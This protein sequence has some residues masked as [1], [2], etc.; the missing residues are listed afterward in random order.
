[1]IEREKISPDDG[2]TL[3]KSRDAGDEAEK[4]PLRLKIENFFY[5]YKWHTIVALFL[6]FAVVIS[7][8]QLCTRVENDVCLLYAGAADVKKTS[9][10][11]Q[12]SPYETLLSVVKT[13]VEDYTGDGKIQVTFEVLFTLSAEERAA[14]EQRLQDEGGQYSL[15]DAQLY[16]NANS[17][18]DNMT[19]GDFYVCLLSEANFRQ[20][21]DLLAEIAPYTNGNES[22]YVFLSDKGIY[23]SSTALAKKPGF[24]ALPEDTVICLR[25]LSEVSSRISGKNQRKYENAENFLRA[26]LAAG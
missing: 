23:L 5:Y 26:L 18:R 17:L 15:N 13:Y 7:T 3:G 4:S 19:I 8:V 6:I 21:E 11:G 16:Q 25:R 22:D 24:D 12:P 9:Q 1:M 14:I 10:N 2:P 20:Y